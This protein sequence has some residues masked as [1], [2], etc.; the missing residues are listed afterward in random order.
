M[1]IAAKSV[2][3]LFR[4]VVL[5]NCIN[6]DRW[7]FSAAAAAAAAVT[8]LFVWLS[9]SHCSHDISFSQ[10]LNPS[11]GQVSTKATRTTVVH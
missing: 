10:L 5:Y 8:I 3:R 1:D 2:R 4:V 11:K 7:F 9:L 6:P